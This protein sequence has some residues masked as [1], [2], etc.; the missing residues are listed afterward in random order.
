[1]NQPPLPKRSENGVRLTV[2]LGRRTDHPAGR[3]HFISHSVLNF[4]YRRS[5]I[6][7]SILQFTRLRLLVPM[8][9]NFFCVTAYHL[10][11][12]GQV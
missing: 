2:P 8:S 6:G 4:L 9:D 12:M 3:K 10:N 7:K 5:V 1:M 11:S